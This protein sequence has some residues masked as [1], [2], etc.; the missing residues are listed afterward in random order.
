M[1]RANSVARPPIKAAYFGRWQSLIC[2][3]GEELRSLSNVVERPPT[4]TSQISETTLRNRLAAVLDRV[5]RGEELIVEYRGKPFAALIP[6]AKIELMRRLARRRAL[7][8]LKQQCDGTL[9]DAEAT[10]LGLEAQRWA[11]RKPRRTAR[12]RRAR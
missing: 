9:T 10:E 8:V 4:M 1:G 7:A 2:E 12:R 6:A 3:F 5:S 11:R